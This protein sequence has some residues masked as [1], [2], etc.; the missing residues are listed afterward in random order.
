MAR[1][2]CFRPLLFRPAKPRSTW[3]SDTRKLITMCCGDQRSLRILPC[4]GL[5]CQDTGAELL[6]GQCTFPPALIRKVLCSQWITARQR[7]WPNGHLS[8][9]LATLRSPHHCPPG[10][11]S[12][13][14]PCLAAE[15]V[16]AGCRQHATLKHTSGSTT[17]FSLHP[18][19]EPGPSCK[20]L[21]SSPALSQT[22]RSIPA[23][24]KRIG[25][26]EKE[27]GEEDSGQTAP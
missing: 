21:I 9:I 15:Q 24:G 3:S 5:S 22:L 26:R 6:G 14:S 19:R 18:C 25:D 16:R 2:S 11:S 27:W 7:T 20:L 1:S 8:P 17:A 12:P 4:T 10:L 23:P 13:N